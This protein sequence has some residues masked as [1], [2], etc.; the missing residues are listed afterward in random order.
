MP[1][2]LS[3]LEA[4][5]CQAVAGVSFGQ[6]LFDQQWQSLREYAR[7]RDITLLGGAPIFVAHDSAEVWAHR[8]LFQLD[9]AGQPAF[10]AGVPPDY[11]SATGQRWGNPWYDWDTMAKQ[12]FAWWLDRLH[13]DLNRVDWLRID[14]FRGL[15]AYWAIP[16]A[17]E[18][19]TYGEWRA[20]PGHAFLHAVQVRFGEI[21]L[22]AEDL[23][24]ITPA[25]EALRD[26]FGLPGMKVLQ[27]AFE[28]D[29][30]KTYLPHNHRSDCIV[31]TGTHDNDTSVGW[32]TGL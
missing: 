7:E 28:Q 10:V 20:A 22:V 23:G 9:A 1:R 4:N 19:A 8:E 16:V 26:C 2:A 12:D 6:A 18:T 17:N 27:F 25:V 5:S 30:H 11:F 13:T 14:H 31:Y 3:E 24:I 15:E 29:P 21:P 32:V